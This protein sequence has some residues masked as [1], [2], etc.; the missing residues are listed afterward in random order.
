MYPIGK[1][2]AQGSDILCSVDL[3][4]T[5]TFSDA[6]PAAGLT[7]TNFLSSDAFHAV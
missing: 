7:K 4:R 1:T 3:H 2:A 6:G 5:P